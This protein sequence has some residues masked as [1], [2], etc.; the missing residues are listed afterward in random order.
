M[1]VT[2]LQ[3]MAEREGFAVASPTGT[4]KF[5]GGRFATWNAGGCCGDARDRGVDDVGF[6][7]AGGGRCA[8]APGD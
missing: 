4:A 1:P 8:A 6:A 2:G 7:R 5:P 3:S